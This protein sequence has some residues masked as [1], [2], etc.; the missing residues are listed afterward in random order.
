[1]PRRLG[2]PRRPRSFRALGRRPPAPPSSPRSARRGEELERDAVGIAEAQ[3][4][5]VGRVLDAAV[6]D[7]ELVETPRPLLEIIAA[8]AAERDVVESQAELAEALIRRAAPV[9]VQPEQGAAAEEVHR[10]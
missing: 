10:V 4:R 6:V 2:V 7:P 3:T 1:M 9:L 8:L 5:S